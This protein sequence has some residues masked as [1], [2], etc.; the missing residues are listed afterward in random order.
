[1]RRK[2]INTVFN[3]F[4]GGIIDMVK[5][6]ILIN[7]FVHMPTN[8]HHNQNNENVHH[9]SKFLSLFLVPGNHCFCFSNIRLKKTSEVMSFNCSVVGHVIST[10]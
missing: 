4:M 9:S 3:S 1:M 8:P 6:Y 5:V 10:G 2:Y 7:C